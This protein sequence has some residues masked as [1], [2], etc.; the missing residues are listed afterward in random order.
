VVVF[1]VHLNGRRIA[2]AGTEDLGVLSTIVSAV[3]KLG[4]ATKRR[5]NEGYDIDIRVGGL[6]ARKRGADEH[7]D[8]VRRSLKIGDEIYLRVTRGEHANPPR[9]RTPRDKMPTISE[10]K[11]FE[12]AKALYYQLRRK[13]EGR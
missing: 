6:T 1:E 4:P 8:W 9:R 10:R 12:F 7:V 5:R 11:R 13:Y 3:G 2:L